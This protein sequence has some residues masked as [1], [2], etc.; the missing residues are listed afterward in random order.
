MRLVY[1]LLLLVVAA[2]ADGAK[3]ISFNKDIRPILAD[4]CFICHG[5]DSATREAGL[6]LDREESAKGKLEDSGNIAI[7]AGDLEASE[8]LAR[9]TDPDALMPPPESNLKVS[10]QEIELIRQW[11]AEGAKWE[12]HWAFIPPVKSD[13]PVVK[14]TSWPI[15]EIDSFILH[16]LESE[17]LRPTRPADR[18]RWLRRVTFDLTGLPPTLEQLDAFSQD[19]SQD[20]WSKVVDRLLKVAC[21]RRA[22]GGRVAGCGPLW[23]YGRPV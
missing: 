23:R 7:V 19:S 16:R 15:N 9:L 12:R 14:K 2:P 22:D 8:L 11:I 6:R 5:P 1:L 13:L 18:A 4:R 17:G 10:K 21:V 3:P 20:A